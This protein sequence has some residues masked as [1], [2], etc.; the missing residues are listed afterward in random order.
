MLCNM[1]SLTLVLKQLTEKAV[2]VSS[3]YSSNK[4]ENI[5]DVKLSLSLQYLYTYM[6]L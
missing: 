4:G 1:C 6:I 2:V 5:F 3:S